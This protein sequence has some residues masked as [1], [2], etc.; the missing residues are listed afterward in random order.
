MV[1]RNYFE[2]IVQRSIKLLNGKPLRQNTMKV[3]ANISQLGFFLFFYTL[4]KQTKTIPFSEVK[5][6]RG[7]ITMDQLWDI[8]EKIS[9]QN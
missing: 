2:Q 1:T 8:H 5:A 9:K 6:N 3:D 7:L 4:N